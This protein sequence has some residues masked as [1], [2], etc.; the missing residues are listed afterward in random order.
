VQIA[1]VDLQTNRIDG[2]GL[3]KTLERCIQSKYNDDDGREQ[4]QRALELLS[5]ESIPTL[6][7][8][9]SETTGASDDDCSQVTPWE[10]LTTTVGHSAHKGGSTLGS[11][12]LGK[13]AAFAVTPLRTV[14]YSTCYQTDPAKRRFIGRSILVTHYDEKGRKLS[15]DGFL[16]DG[17]DALVDNDIPARFQMPARGTKVLI[18]GWESSGK[19]DE[20]KSRALRVIAANFFWAILNNHLT[21]V[22]GDND[23][24]FLERDSLLPGGE[25][26]R[27]LREMGN[28]GNLSRD[29]NKTLRYID[30]SNQNPAAE[31]YFPCVGDVELR[32]GV[33]IEGSGH[34]DIALVRE[35]GLF[36]TDAA[37]HLGRDLN[38]TIPRF[39]KDF[40]AVVTVKP[41]KGED[42]QNGKDGDWVLRD[43]ETPAHNA[44]DVGRIRTTR[45]T[46]TR[47]DARKA[48]RQVQ[49]WL[50]EEIEKYANPGRDSVD[51][52]DDP[53][54]IELGLFVESD[55]DGDASGGPGGDK[56][57]R[58]IRLGNVRVT[59]HIPR[60]TTNLGFDVTPTETK[61]DDPSGEEE[62]GDVYVPEG[63]RR[64]LG[65]DDPP[66][67]PNPDKPTNAPT[68]TRTTTKKVARPD[69]RPV[70]TSAFTGENGQR[71]TH[72]FKVALAIP[73]GMRNKDLQ[74]RVTAVL[75]DTRQTPIRLMSV[76]SKNVSLEMADQTKGTFTVP[77]SLTAG[78][79]RLNLKIRANEPIE[80]TAF[81]VTAIPLDT[82]ESSQ[83]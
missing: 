9:D 69:L 67:P 19:A 66:G 21:V 55:Q 3:A 34:R 51:D 60:Q 46:K 27:M 2:K 83:T 25:A 45:K 20:W 31:R 50:K 35:P 5:H 33:G 37:K 59:K 65:P 57:G 14:L 41:R 48:L 76:K 68:T 81:D 23:A 77:A 11:F 56:K 62:P 74:I 39:W 72:A 38:P 10:G 44:I 79:S 22:L 28:K 52:W 63:E 73:S 64:Q 58:S 70:F 54:L 18:P 24:L 17:A 12:G 36:I 75:E 71:D 80:E 7:I 13:H 43:C 16:G 49:S 8:T 32:I 26:R 15:P 42:R 40:T 47:S 61:V 78:T 82:S 30:I 29:I 1:V 53:G 4:F 6:E